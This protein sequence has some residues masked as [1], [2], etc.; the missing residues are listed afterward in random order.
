MTEKNFRYPIMLSGMGMAFSSVASFIVCRVL[1]LIELKK[2]D[3]M[4][5]H[6]YLS[7]IMPV[8]VFMASTLWFGNKERQS[9]VDCEQKK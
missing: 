9:V 7:K 6:F 1:K 4:T 3:S 5:P 2:W 8:G